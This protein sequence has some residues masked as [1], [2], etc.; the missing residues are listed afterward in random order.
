MNPLNKFINIAQAWINASNP[1]PEEK[2]I[3]KERIKICNYCNYAQDMPVV[4]YLC[5]QCYCP[6]SKK[7]FSPKPDCPLNKWKR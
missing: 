7:I 1:T 4:G 3:S 2:Q 6:L 5:T